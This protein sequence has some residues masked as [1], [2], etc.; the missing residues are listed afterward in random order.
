MKSLFYLCPMKGETIMLKIRVKEYLREQGIAQKDLAERL[1][2]SA[3]VLSKRISS[4]E[5]SVTQLSEI[6][7]AL[8]V[9]Y[10]LLLTD[11][12][13]VAAATVCPHCGESLHLTLINK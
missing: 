3:S 10:T 4:E 12:D 9:S 6:A 7:D 1:G 13:E 11:T 2:I 5:L 8:G